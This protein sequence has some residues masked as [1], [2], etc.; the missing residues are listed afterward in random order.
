MSACVMLL[1]IDI[2][3]SMGGDRQTQH[4]I[5]A[6]EE[7]GKGEK[8]CACLGVCPNNCCVDARNELARQSQ[9]DRRK[10]RD[11]S[12]LSLW[13][14]CRPLH[15]ILSYPSLQHSANSIALQLCGFVRH[16]SSKVLSATR[17][18]Q[19]HLAARYTHT[20]PRPHAPCTMHHATRTN[21]SARPITTRN[22]QQHFLKYSSF[23][24]PCYPLLL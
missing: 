9:E 18:T 13:R 16:A 12:M 17:N 11:T 2:C 5:G 8:R 21:H 23:L 1:D 22:I 3:W 19:Q 15:P 4:D 24:S 10:E 20:S 14:A 6:V 7:G